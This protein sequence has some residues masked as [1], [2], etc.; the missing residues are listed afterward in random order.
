MAVG[1]LDIRAHSRTLGHCVA[2]ALAYRLGCD[3]TDS[4]TGTEHQYARRGAAGEVA[5]AGF[6]HGPTTPGWGPGAQAW[7]DALEG[8]ERRSNSVVCRDM[9]IALPLGL[10]L[11]EA[12]E[13]THEL[14]QAMSDDYDTVTA[15]AIHAADARGDQ[16]NLHAHILMS[17]RALDPET[18]MPGAKLRQ[19]HV[20]SRARARHKDS[21]RE[22]RRTD[23]GGAEEIRRIR[24]RWERIANTHLAQTG[25]TERI[26]MGRVQD[27][28]DRRPVLTRGEVIAERIL[29]SERHAGEP[30]RPMPVKALVLRNFADGGCR[31]QRGRELVEHL[32]AQHREQRPHAGYHRADLSELEPH[33]IEIT[34]EKTQTMQPVVETPALRRTERARK[35]RRRRRARTP[36][37][38]AQAHP[39]RRRPSEQAGISSEPE[40]TATEAAHTAPDDPLEDPPSAGPQ[41]AR[42]PTPPVQTEARATPAPTTAMHVSPQPPP[43]L[44]RIQDRDMPTTRW[45]GVAQPMRTIVR[46]VFELPTRIATALERTR[47]PGWDYGPIQPTRVGTARRLLRAIL[48][49]R[50]ATALERTRGPGWDYG[51][52]QRTRVGAARRMLRTILP[53]PIATALE[54]IRGEAYDYGPIQPT[55][56]RRA[57]LVRPMTVDFEP[58]RTATRRA[59]EIRESLDDAPRRGA[60]ARPRQRGPDRNFES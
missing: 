30:L 29:W 60:E 32:A 18:G 7:A 2:A 5:A 48:P 54:R 25:R 9:T 4:H 24:A 47:G 39:E 56:A 46:R 8:A 43:R 55:R 33:E 12:I 26:A 51:P 36:T 6:C 23:A 42:T 27:D 3:L 44:A 35:R 19:F 50:I 28:R 53:T 20:R 40:P 11:E 34:I 1:H 45:H 41:L 52:I 37:E 49:T 17:T 10:S 58:Y 57:R 22:Q 38:P 59:I 21:A 16:R 13:A 15:W 31:T 14:A